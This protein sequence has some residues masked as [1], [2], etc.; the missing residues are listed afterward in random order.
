MSVRRFVLSVFIL[1]QSC[2]LFTQDLLLNPSYEYGFQGDT[3]T[4][5]FH[6]SNFEDIGSLQFT[7]NWDPAIIQYLDI[8][9]E[10]LGSIGVNANE[11]D[12][13][14]LRISWFG[15]SEALTIPEEDPVFEIQFLAIGDP[16]AISSIFISGD[17]LF[18]EVLRMVDGSPEIV[19]INSTPGNV[20]ILEDFL[21]VIENVV[22][23]TCQNAD[24]EVSIAVSGGLSPYTFS[25]TGPNGFTETIEDVN[26]LVG[27]S[28]EV[29][30][31][32]SIGNMLVDTVTVEQQTND[33]T[34]AGIV[35]QDFDCETQQTT[36]ELLV[37]GGDMPYSISVDEM[38]INEPFIEVDSGIHLLSII[39]SNDCQIDTS[40]E[41]ASVPLPMVD[42]GNDVT[43]C[44]GETVMLE[45]VFPAEAYL[46]STGDETSAINVTEEGDYVLQATNPQGCIASDTIN[47]AF[48]LPFKA[49]LNIGDTTICPGE[50]VTIEASGGVSY[51]WIDNSGT[52][53]VLDSNRAV[54][55]PGQTTQYAVAAADECFVDTAYVQITVGQALAD[56]GRDTSVFAGCEL[57]LNAMGGVQYLWDTA[58]EMSC[59]ECPD[60][61][62]IPESSTVY[63]V[64][65][66]DSLGCNYL[67]SVLVEVTTDIS[68][69]FK[70]INVITPNNDGDNDFLWFEGLEKFPANNIKVFNRWGNIVYQKIGYQTDEERWDGTYNGKLLPP[71]E[72][73]Y[74]LSV[75]SGEIKQTL[76]IVRD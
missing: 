2:V 11:I 9:S 65:I 18:I 33:L 42:L 38:M 67:D 3:V 1:L 45:S 73:Y 40:F 17:P 20:E 56:A 55:Q 15:L 74:V 76:L 5:R 16:G 6:S 13:G 19:G 44:A 41:I 35:E 61:V 25:W 64:T 46:W 60:P 30:V 29:I 75:T 63:Y 32:D 10:H 69:L 39:D 31:L 50:S 58:E 68:D 14:L 34:F 62:V 47:V 37:A 36:V 48:Q 57:Q 53:S 23:A 27:G 22:D 70:P 52:L 24:G 43:A 28:Y 59:Y 26:Q 4:V 21:L 66:T 51:D 8:S 49:E 72:Y 7:L 12:Q 71:G 54:V